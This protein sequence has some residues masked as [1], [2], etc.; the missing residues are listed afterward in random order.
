MLQGNLAETLSRGG[1]SGSAQ[2]TNQTR[3]LLVISEVALALILLVGAGLTI[4]S[5]YAIL[6]VDTG[7]RADHLLT[8]HVNLPEAR[9]PTDRQVRSFSQLMLDKLAQIPGVESVT[10]ASALPIL[11]NIRA[12]SFYIEGTPPADPLSHQSLTGS[13]Q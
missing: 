2:V 4:R 11:D 1:R 10:I 9:Y 3:R 13:R 5:L 12:N 8:M 6:S 7:F